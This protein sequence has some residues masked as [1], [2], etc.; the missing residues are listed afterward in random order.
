MNDTTTDRLAMEMETA[1]RNAWASLSRYKFLLFGYWAGVWVHLNKIA[2]DKQ[3][4]PWRSLVHIARSEPAASARHVGEAIVDAEGTGSGLDPLT[5]QDMA[6]TYE[7]RDIV[8]GRQLAQMVEEDG[9]D[10]IDYHRLSA[11]AKTNRQWGSDLEQAGA[12]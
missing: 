3:S 4:N 10:T 11:L 1:E 6:I 2:G 12:R 8:F 9:G 5:L 7:Y